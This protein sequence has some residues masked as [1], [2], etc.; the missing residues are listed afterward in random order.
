MQVLRTHKQA[1]FHQVRDKWLSLEWNYKN[2]KNICS[3]QINGFNVVDRRLNC[4]RKTCPQYVGMQD[5]PRFM[6]ELF[7]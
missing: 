6:N 4:T 5:I 3:Q 7:I 2:L 1:N